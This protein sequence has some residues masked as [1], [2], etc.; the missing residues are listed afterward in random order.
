MMEHYD[1]DQALLLWLETRLDDGD[2]DT[3]HDRALNY[4]IGLLLSDS[5]ARD[6]APLARV[7]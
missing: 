3:Y 7:S 5:D 6:A 4:L 2:D 1:L